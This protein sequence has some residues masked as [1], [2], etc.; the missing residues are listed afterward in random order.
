M[1]IH[2]EMLQLLEAGRRNIAH[3]EPWLLEFSMTQ[4]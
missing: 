1:V 2:K 3:L 4:E